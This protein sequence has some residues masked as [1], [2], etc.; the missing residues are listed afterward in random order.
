[1]K[2]LESR[3]KYEFKRQDLLASALTHK[4]FAHEKRQGAA[5]NEKLEFLGDAVLDLVLGEYLIELFPDDNEGA[6]SK[7]RAS[8]VNEEMLARL[9]MEWDI[10][11]YLQLGKGEMQTGGFLKPR[12]LASAVEALIGALYLDAGFEE[13]R[14]LLRREYDP[15][16][17]GLDLTHDFASDYKTRLQ[18]VAQRMQR[19]TPAYELIGEEGPSHDRVFTV[20]VKLRDSELARGQGRSKKSAEQEAAR[21]ALQDP[22]FQEGES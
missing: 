2:A 7:K 15:L 9:S 1:M 10:P 17:S 20:A 3:L 4:S 19:V 8:L 16:I 5:H 14:R 11:E 12:L 21:A 13:A 6:L 22:R 18:E